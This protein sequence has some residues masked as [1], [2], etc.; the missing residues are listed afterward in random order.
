MHGRQ[1]SVDAGKHCQER[2]TDRQTQTQRERERERETER[3]RGRQGEKDVTGIWILG[4]EILLDWP[5]SLW[6]LV[7]LSSLKT[8][9]LDCIITAVISVYIEEKLTKIGEFLCSHF[10]IEDG[11][12]YATFSAYYALLFK[13]K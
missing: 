8:I 11:R 5:K 10:N 3:D 4:Y 12:K 9:L 13:E 6:W 1:E 7:S 2:Q